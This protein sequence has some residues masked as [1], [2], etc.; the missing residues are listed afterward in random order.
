[1]ATR[2]KRKTSS[3]ESE[4]SEV[5]DNQL[6]DLFTNSSFVNE[7]NDDESE[8]EESYFS[9]LEEEISSDEEDDKSEEDDDYRSEDEDDDTSEE[10][11]DEAS[12]S[13]DEKT[14]INQDNK[15]MKKK[16]K[17]KTRQIDSRMEKTKKEYIDSGIENSDPIQDEYEY[18]SS[19]EEDIRNT[20]GNIPMQWYNDYPHIGYDLDGKRISKPAQGDELDE[21]LNKMENPDYWITVK[22]K[23][24]GENVV[25][26]DEELDI[27]ERIEK[28]RYPQ[29]EYDPYEP[30]VDFFTK[31]TMI[32]PVTR[33]PEHKRSFIPSLIEKEK[34]LAWQQQDP[35]DR[36]LNYL[37]KKFDCLR[38][39]P[40]YSN[41]IREQFERCLDLYL[42]PR[43]RKMR[44]QVNP[45]D[46]IPKL[47][48]P[49]ELQPFPTVQAIV[50]KGHSN[51][52]RSIS[53]DPSGQ[54]L[55][56]GS[57][58]STVKLWEVISGRCLK[59]IPV[60]GAVHCVAWCPNVLLSLLA[61][62]VDD[63]VHI[64]NTGLGDKLLISGT[65]NVIENYEPAEDST[66][67]SVD[68]VQAEDDLHDIG[69]RLSIKHPKLAQPP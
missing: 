26:T 45:E 29:V 50:Y 64:L 40:A 33:R 32:H 24:T 69:F 51:L 60:S 20:V 62:V 66:K 16:T 47:P 13:A 15:S 31:E 1:M 17:R 14:S 63:N 18:D 44:V 65:D 41:F 57:D 52:I 10:N 6:D 48:K 42:C 55:A 35:E 21:F 43:Q 8:S 61:I 36:R 49:K 12:T 27:I 11:S 37:P 9:E 2:S 58:D 68:W 25:L 19:D 30:Y 38:K 23:M 39:V 28:G 7:P 59:T 34:A 67:S 53:V 3:K 54:W 22:N 56:S 5:T 4:V 46:L